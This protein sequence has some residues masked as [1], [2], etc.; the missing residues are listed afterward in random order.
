ME[1]SMIDIFKPLERKKAYAGR[2]QRALRKD[3]AVSAVTDHESHQYLK[4]ADLATAVPEA[5]CKLSSAGT[6]LQAVNTMHAE[7]PGF[8]ECQHLPSDK[9]QIS[10]NPT[11][12][13]VGNQEEHFVPNQSSP[14]LKLKD[15]DWRT[16]AYTDSSCH[17][18][19]GKQEIGAGVYCPLTSSKILSSLMVLELPTPHVELN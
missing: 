5:K 17:I 3:H 2:N 16:W 9:Q 11:Y 13:H 4:L 6:Q 12:P 15:P 19:N 8:R 10:R 7:M 1:I 18:Q 14:T